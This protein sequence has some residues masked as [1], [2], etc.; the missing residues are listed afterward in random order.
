M[1]EWQRTDE[2]YA[3]RIANL[4]TGGGLN[5]SNNLILGQTVL[6]NAAADILTGGDGLDWFWS[7]PGDTITDLNRGGLETVN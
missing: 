6:G 7:L 5:G 3:Q 4:R 1:S 2:T